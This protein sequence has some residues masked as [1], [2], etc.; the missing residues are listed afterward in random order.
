MKNKTLVFTAT[1]N[2]SENIK[3]FLDEILKIKDIDILIIDDNSP[4]GTSK[5]ISDYKKNYN[6]LNLII[7]ENKQG[8]DTA[9]KHAYRYA[10]EKGYQNFITMD[11][12]LSH[13][14]SKI[15][16]FLDALKS[17]SFVIGSRYIKGGRNETKLTRYLLSI[18]G[19]KIIKIVLNINC[20]EFTTSYR[21][22]NI[23]ELKK[24]DI[25]QVKSQGYSFFM[26]T[27][28]QINKSGYSVEQIP[29]IFADR[30]K[31]VSKIPKIET[32]RTL[33]NLF[34]LKFTR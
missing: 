13:D 26:E 17:N 31:G 32:L 18:I 11:A 25:N 23:N 16:I 24:F 9:H 27:I 22:F 8:L 28:Y 3:N 7:R 12:D 20:E 2:E 19:N 33:K 10:K 6:N 1:Y 34:L 4:D 29:I 21:G 15:P 30:K 14:P 5:I